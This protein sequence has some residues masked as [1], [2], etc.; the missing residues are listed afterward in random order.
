V[1]WTLSTVHVP[2]GTAVATDIFP[3]LLRIFRTEVRL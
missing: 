2:A 1:E 3:L